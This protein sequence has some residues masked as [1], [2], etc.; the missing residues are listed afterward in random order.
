MT[1]RILMPTDGSSCSEHAI[2]EGLAL[3]KSLDAQVTFLAAVEDPRTALHSV[4]DATQ[5]MPEFREELRKTA[6][7]ALTRA[8]SLAEEAGVTAETKL[9]ERQSPI[10]AIHDAEE[11]ADMVVMGTHGRRGFNHML[12]G[13]VAEGA[14]RRSDKPYVLIRSKNGEA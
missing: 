9:V 2:R 4:H 14:L 13:S 5:F 1:K 10:Q 8:T 3:A 6:E 12:F 7:Q 11:N